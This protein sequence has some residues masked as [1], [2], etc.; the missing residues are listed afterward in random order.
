[1]RDKLEQEGSTWLAAGFILAA[2]VPLFFL[3]LG[4]RIIWIPL[5]ARYAL[6]AR[7]MWEG[8][9]WILPH[10]GGMVYPDK[11]P[12]LFWSIGLLS[13]LGSGVTEW[14]ARLPSALAAVCVC[15]MTWR[16]GA[17]LLSPRAG[18]L[19]AFV[20][21]TS[22]GFFWSGRQASPDMLL[23]L[24]VT[25]AC[26]ALWEWLTAK[27]Q[28]G[29]IIAGLCMGVA[30]LAKG[31]VGFL[32]P[33]LTALAYLAVQRDW[34]VARGRDVMLCVGSFLVA[35]LAWYL[36]AI[37]EGG[38]TYAQ[39]TLLHHSLE[40]Y[41]KAWEHAAP[42]YFYLG[43]F[44]A[45]FLPW[46][47]FLPQALILG[48]ARLGQEDLRGW[49]F[50]LCWL[51][52]ILI[53]FSISSGK[54]DIY[55]LPAFPAAALL[56]GWIWSRWWDG[57]RGRWG[58][59]GAV[60]PALLLALALWGLAGGN[61]GATREMLPSRNVLL[62]PA[63]PQARLWAVGLLG[64][65][66]ILLASAAITRR[67]RCVY[68]CVAGCAWLAMIT[69]VLL[70][71]TP[72]FNQRYPIRSFAQAILARI[73]AGWPLHV[74][75]HLNDLALNFNL[76]RVLPALPEAQEVARYLGSSDPVYCVMDLHVYTRISELTGQRYPVFVRQQ[77][78]RSALLL[79]S[80]QLLIRQ[81]NCSPTFP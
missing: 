61:W 49:G 69:G 71:Y 10:L 81:S 7:E 39:D 12:L 48:A 54:R 20:L 36:P 79:V 40:R 22:G 26:W 5:E 37:G 78:D 30:T 8:G 58:T 72:Q 32:L 64:L 34:H 50:A 47:L 44:P 53:F 4:D 17:R 74:C 56:V 60:V 16:M 76:G 80:N 14:T 25:G 29:A 13:A 67:P 31:P 77:I 21:A 63:T 51:V 38:L 52:T 18:L 55:S 41:A 57:F 27:Q 59:W 35:T 15:L 68:R 33:T 42:W 46:T 1:M 9:H 2:T 73:D 3:G 23:T 66:G 65:G 45:E 75:G 62:L 70:I 43:A 24:W 19:A 11:P 6:V 28:V